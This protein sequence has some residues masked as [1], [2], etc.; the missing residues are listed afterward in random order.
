MFIR[1][2]VSQLQPLHSRAF[3]SFLFFFFRLEYNILE[4]DAANIE[5]FYK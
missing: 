2:C 4:R 1:A 3:F 5:T